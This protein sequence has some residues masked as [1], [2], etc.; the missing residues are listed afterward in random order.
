MENKKLNILL[1]EDDKNLGTVLKAYLDAKG[2]HCT[3]CVN[4]KEALEQYKE[5]EFDFLILDVMMPKKHGWQVCD[6]INKDA[7]LKDIIVVMLTAVGEAVQTTNYTHHSG[8]T[9]L[10][11]DYLEKPIDLHLIF[12]KSHAP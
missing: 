5:N 2:F 8:K 3:L 6:E 7:Q 1:A 9:T 10:A 11:D 4:G 12:H